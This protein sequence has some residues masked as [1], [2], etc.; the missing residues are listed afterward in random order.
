M[1]FF[2]KKNKANPD[3]LSKTMSISKT[4][5]LWNLRPRLNKKSSILNQFNVKG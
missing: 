4:H 5:N 3:K 2:F 1:S